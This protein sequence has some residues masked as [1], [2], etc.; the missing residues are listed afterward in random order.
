M[1]HTTQARAVR[2]G[3]V[4]SARPLDAKC[5]LCGKP[6]ATVPLHLHLA[7]GTYLLIGSMAHP[8]CYADAEQ[9]AQVQ[10]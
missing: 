7:T 8:M 1:T 5:E 9:S 6:G 3:A 4:V 10:S 2:A